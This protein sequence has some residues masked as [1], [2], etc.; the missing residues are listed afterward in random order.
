VAGNT[1]TLYYGLY[2]SSDG[3]QT[4]SPANAGMQTTQIF[5]IAV[6]PTNA[7]LVYISTS[8]AFFKSADGGTT[9]TQLAAYGGGPI[10][11][12][13]VHVHSLY[14]SSAADIMRSVD[15]GTSWEPIPMPQSL[16]QSAIN[17]LLVDPNRTSDLLVATN[18]AGVQRITIAPDVALQGASTASAVVVGTP[19]TYGYTVVNNGPYSVSGVQV[20][21]Q[22]PATA[23]AFTATSTVGT[24]TVN[25]ATATCSIGVLSNAA[26]ATISLT[27]TASTVGAF[28]ISGSAQADQAD[29]NTTNNTTTTTVTVA[30]AS[31]SGSAPPSGSSGSGT[32]ASG[33]S[34]GG[35]A[36]SPTLLL[37]LAMLLAVKLWQGRRLNG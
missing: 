21:L 27:A 30:A 22:L 32:T 15:G 2:R 11:M 24:C 23:Q 19:T 18:G 9:W 8:T 3:G 33:G 31:G 26:S 10:A 17:S 12:D 14:V 6:D 4:W 13:P 1:S 20:T 7:Q 28:Q 29:S 36:L 5:A 25:G 37:G 34:H 35:G 16:V